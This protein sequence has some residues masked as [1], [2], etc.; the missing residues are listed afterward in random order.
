MYTRI[1]V[2]KKYKIKKVCIKLKQK[3]HKRREIYLFMW[4]GSLICLRA[5]IVTCFK[6]DGGLLI[7]KKKEKK[8]DELGWRS[9]MKNNVNGYNI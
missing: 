6:F 9:S 3:E 1:L 4:L 8:K 7:L 2:K 5:L